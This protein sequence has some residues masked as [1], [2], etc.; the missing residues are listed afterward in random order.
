M[1]QYLVKRLLGLIPTLA[2]VALLV[3]LFVHLL[4][5]DPARLAAGPDATPQTVAL[6]RQDLGLDKSLPEQFVRFTTGVLHG[7]FGRSLRT[8]R[9]VNAE[10]AERFMPTFWLTVTSMAWSVA[11]GMLIG[12]LSAVWR[13]RWPDRLHCK[14]SYGRGGGLW[15]R[16]FRDRQSKRIFRRCARDIRRSG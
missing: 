11:I 2:L 6:V 9:P 10:I 16:R 7:D 14:R 13:N 1:L 15:D 3:F 8:K 12:T 5:G 4:P